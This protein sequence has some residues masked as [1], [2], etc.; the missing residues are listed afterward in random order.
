[1]GATTF[2]Y[3]SLAG[4]PDLP[5]A[6][7]GPKARLSA[8]L[9]GR[10]NLAV[11]T[12][13]PSYTPLPA[14]AAT[15]A[16]VGSPLVRDAIIPPHRAPAG[17]SDSGDDTPS[18]PRPS[19]GAAEARDRLACSGGRGRHVTKAGQ[20]VTQPGNRDGPVAKVSRRHLLEGLAGLEPG[21]TG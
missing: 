10:A 21:T 19:R 2:S 4:T 9:P 3:Q 17:Q 11:S 18:P 13:V 12:Q 8:T 7:A 6:R 15:H 1:M 20:T 16:L 5:P 14:P